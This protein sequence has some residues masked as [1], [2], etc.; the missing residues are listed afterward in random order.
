MEKKLSQKRI[1]IILEDNEMMEEIQN[2]VRKAKE[3]K[4]CI[5]NLYYV[6]NRVWNEKTDIVF[7]D[8]TPKEKLFFEKALHF[9]EYYKDD[10]ALLFKKFY[11]DKTYHIICALYIA[12][13]KMHDF[14]QAELIEISDNSGYEICKCDHLYTG[15]IINVLYYFFMYHLEYKD[16]QKP[17]CKAAYTSNK[18]ITEVEEFKNFCY[19]NN[20]STSKRRKTLSTA[21]SAIWV[22]ETFF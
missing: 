6:I 2:I 22:I 3:E 9:M 13:E 12:A 1:N 21:I 10:F 7:S 15:R 17:V 11:F 8:P 19:E 14:T 4:L 18:W 16:N 20:Y 5:S